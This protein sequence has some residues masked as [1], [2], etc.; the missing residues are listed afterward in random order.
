MHDFVGFRRIFAGVELPERAEGQVAAE[1][2]LVEGHR[3]AGVLAEAKVGVERRWHGRFSL[4]YRTETESEQSTSFRS[5]RR[6]HRGSRQ[7]D[8]PQFSGHKAV[9]H[10]R[11]REEVAG[12]PGSASSFRRN[13]AMYT[14]R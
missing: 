3:L 4:K 1:D 5:S 7:P 11:F 9:A 12:F 6:V 13:W 2:G 14:R 10:T 8:A